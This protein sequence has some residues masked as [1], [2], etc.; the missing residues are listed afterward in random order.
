MSVCVCVSTITQKIMHG[1]SPNFFSRVETLKSSDEFEDGQNPS[2]S[3]KVI[4]DYLL[5]LVRFSIE[6]YIKVSMILD[7][8]CFDV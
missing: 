4:A 1:S 8:K 5:V 2:S 7:I 3:S 6:I